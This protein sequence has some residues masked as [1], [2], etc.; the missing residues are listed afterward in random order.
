M[1][2]RGDTVCTAT[3]APR[4]CQR[5]VLGLISF[6]VYSYGNSNSLRKLNPVT[7]CHWRG[8]VRAVGVS[9]PR[10]LSFPHALG[11]LLGD[12]GRKNHDIPDTPTHPFAEVV[13]RGKKCLVRRETGPLRDGPCTWEAA[14]RGVAP[15]SGWWPRKPLISCGCFPAPIAPPHRAPSS[16]AFVLTVPLSS[17]WFTSRIGG[18]GGTR[19]LGLP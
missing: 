13:G 11:T 12:G 19:Q 7:R 8:R 6:T 9:H 17:L 10:G 18:P 4:R 2:T 14:R 16:L 3:L 15:A 1:E 5:P